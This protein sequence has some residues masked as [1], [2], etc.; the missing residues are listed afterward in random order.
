MPQP[1]P[2]IRTRTEHPISRRNIDPD[3]LKVLYRLVRRGHTA[4][5]VGGGVRDLLLG[6]HPKDFDVSTDARPRQIKNLFR[7]AFLIGRRFRLAHIKYGENIIETSTFRANPKTNNDPDDPK[8][9]LLQQQDNTFGTPQEDALRRDFTINGLFYD[10]ENFSVIDYVGG[11]DDLKAR[12]IRCIG[13]PDIRF[14]EDPVRMIRAVRFAGRLN[15]TIEPNTMA[16]I[17]RHHAEIAKA[18]P[19][20][21]L[22]EILRLFAFSAAEKSFQLLHQTKL[23]DIVFPEIS[24][25]L[26]EA[27]AD[28]LL[29]KHLSALDAGAFC[30]ESAPPALMFACLYYD[31]ILR[32]KRAVAPVSHS[33]F[34]DLIKK[35][36][37]PLTQRLPM[38]KRVLDHVRRFI[39]DQDRLCAK[40]NRRFSHTRFASQSTFPGALALLEIHSHATGHEPENLE[41]WRE[42]FSRRPSR[43]ATKPT[44]K[45]RRSSAKKAAKSGRN[46][47]RQAKSSPAPATAMPAGP[48][49][50]Q[51]ST[52]TI[53]HEGRPQD[54]NPDKTSN[55]RRRRRRKKRPVTPETS[56][57]STKQQNPVQIDVSKPISASDLYMSQHAEQ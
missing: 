2:I 27:G 4:Y 39:L 6:R 41:Q 14:R 40:H 35:T 11:L 55:K 46:K 43:P 10:V 45:R 42:L 54:N 7:N 3:A 57:T 1:Q 30:M 23:M 37:T 5:L 15:F 32:K 34:M 24:T 25:Y 21:M 16:A 26:Q 50:T 48:N 33:A 44:G 38:P 36:M 53:T 12:I 51:A 28:A 8:T 52:A 22:E 19:A 47:R 17:S 20:R 56:T 13:D 49:A 18:A 31:M 29:W 9:D